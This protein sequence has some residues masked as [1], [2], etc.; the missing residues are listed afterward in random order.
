[1]AEPIQM[2]GVH[3]KPPLILASEGTDRQYLEPESKETS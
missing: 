1:M 2:L 3:R